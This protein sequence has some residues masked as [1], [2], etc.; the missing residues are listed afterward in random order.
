MSVRVVASCLGLLMALGGCAE[1]LDAGEPRGRP[2]EV[3]DDCNSKSN[4]CG[5]KRLCVAGRCEVAEPAKGSVF[6]PCGEATNDDDGG[7][8]G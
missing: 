6:V 4:A 3:D 2:C 7:V 1:D 5:G 8:G